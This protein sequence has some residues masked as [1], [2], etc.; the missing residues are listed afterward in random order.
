MANAAGNPRICGI[1]GCDVPVDRYCYN[2][3]FKGYK[4]NCAEHLNLQKTARNRILAPLGLQFCSRCRRELLQAEFHSNTNACKACKKAEHLERRYGVTPRIWEQMFDEQR[5]VCS[6]CQVRPP[7][8]VDHD[9]VTGA[10]RGL[11]CHGCNTGIGHLGDSP[12]MVKRALRYLQG[13][14]LEVVASV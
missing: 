1:P 13:A 12:E 5:G 9:H 3:K 8:V 7:A 14:E 4:R 6:I 2:G 11:L 10:I